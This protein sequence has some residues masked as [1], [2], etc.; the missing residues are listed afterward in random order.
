MY[1]FGILGMILLLVVI[2]FVQYTFI[3]G[4]AVPSGSS[5]LNWQCI[6]ETVQSDGKNAPMALTPDGN[7]KCMSLDGKNC[8]WDISCNSKLSTPAASIKPLVCGT[9]HKA[10]WGATGYETKNSWCYKGLQRLQAAVPAQELATNWQCL[11][12]AKAADGKNVPMALT[13]SGDAA[14][15]SLD[16]LNCLW[17]VSCNSKLSTPANTIRALACGSDHNRKWGV[18]G[19]DN[20][21]HWCSRVRETFKAMSKPTITKLVPGDKQ[22]EIQFTAGL[23]GSTITNY[24]Y[25]VDG[26]AT[27]TALSPARSVSPIIIRNLTN[28]TNYTIV[29]R[30]ISNMGTSVASNALTAAP[31]APPA[32]TPAAP[33][34]PTPETKEV[35]KDSPKTVTQE[36]AENIQEASSLVKDLKELLKS[37]KLMFY[38]NQSSDAKKTTTSNGV[39]TTTACLQQGS[40][41]IQTSCPD[42]SQYIRKDQIPCWNCNVEY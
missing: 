34:P 5:A 19:Y 38:L 28:G 30:A 26:G 32:P 37:A 13:T 18:T 9:D 29:L 3:E 6:P 42:M 25:S 35:T 17:D 10:K 36:T 31:V 4:F 14:C 41:M 20:T 7:L 40:E 8:L 39:A 12:S 1:K 16:G 11:E 24:E 27:Y 2:L 23:E 15:M 21:N 33:A 22:L